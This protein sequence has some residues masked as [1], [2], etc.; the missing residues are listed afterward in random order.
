KNSKPKVD[1]VAKA[2][3]GNLCRCTGYNRIIDAVLDAS[4]ST[5]HLQD[6]GEK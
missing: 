6:Q 1:E 3:E 5:S 2:L 4:V